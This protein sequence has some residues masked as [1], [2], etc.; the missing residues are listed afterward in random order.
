MS[1][2]LVIISAPSGTGKTT[3]CKKLLETNNG[4]E[5]SVS[6]TTRSPRPG[7]VNGREYYFLTRDEFEKKIKRGEFAEWE[8]IFHNYYGTL[9]SALEKAIRDGKILLLDVDVKG[10]LNIRKFYPENSVSIFLL[11]PSEEE[12]DRRLRSRGTDN[13]D[14]LRMRK[15]RAH[16]ELKLGEQYDYKIVNDRL[17]ETVNK[18]LEIIEEVKKNGSRHY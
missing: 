10:G 18:V 12:L 5:F 8:E 13:E 4:F 1:G 11:P 7:E 17:D 16:Q 15:K 6:C 9:K 14:S 3:V 2:L